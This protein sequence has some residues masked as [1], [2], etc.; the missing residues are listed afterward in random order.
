MRHLINIITEA[1]KPTKT[2]TDAKPTKTREPQSGLDL[3]FELMPQLDKG[4]VA[5]STAG[6]NVGLPGKKAKRRV[7]NVDVG[8]EGTRHLQTMNRD[9][10]DEISDDEARRRAGV[11]DADDLDVGMPADDDVGVPTQPN[12]ENLPAVIR[13]E[14]AETG[15]KINPEWHQIKH[16]P[17]YIQQPI[18]ALGRQVFGQF[19]DTPIE[20]IQMIGTIG[21]LNPERDVV[22]MMHWIRKNGIQADSAKMDF[23]RFFPEGYQ[24]DV[25]LW[26]TKDYS[27]LL[28]HDFGGY[29]IYG[30]TQKNG[31]HLDQPQR[32]IAAR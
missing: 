9:M 21:G 11:E 20:D 30:W 5:T 24:A 2:H 18:R 7:S 15:G 1:T 25:S 17:N 4:A 22:G 32:R 8:P 16:L 10:Q 3:D 6:R 31:I 14:V 28:V 27:F 19:T 12:V 23:E 29:Y 13:R 26:R